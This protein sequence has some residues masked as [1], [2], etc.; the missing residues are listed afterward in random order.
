MSV[1]NLVIAAIVEEGAGGLRKVYQHGVSAEDF[2]SYEEEFRWIEDRAATKRPINIR[3][4]RRKFEDFEYTPTSERLQDM[5][6]D[7]KNERAYTEMSSLIDSLSAEL[8]VDNAVE[9]AGHA[10]DILAEVTRLH[11]PSSDFALVGGWREH[12]K[13]QRQIR[14][15]RN[16]GEPPGIP[17][18]F[19]H[20]DH[21][22]DGLVQGRMIVV[23]GRPGEGKS[24]L[25][26]A[27]AANASKQK[28]RTLLLSPEMNR[29][30]HLCRLHTLIS[31][32]KK[33]QK[34]CGLKGSFRNR[35]LMRGTGYNIK[36]YGRFMEFMEGEMG[37]IV[38]MTNTHRRTKMTPNF[39][40]A[41]IEEVNPDLVLIDPIYKLHSS[42]NRNSRIEELSDIA[43]AIQDMS[44]AYNIPVVVSNQAH[45]QASG[46]D[47]AP[48]KD[49]SFNSDV[50][51]QEADH[52]IGVKNLSQERRM[53]CRCSKSRFGHDFRFEMVFHPNTGVLQET[54]APTGDY[55]NGHE[56]EMEDEELRQIV[57]AATG[58]NT[59]DA[60]ND[61]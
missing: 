40:E 52:V 32:D 53:I 28:Y 37:E 14:T 16:A 1:E 30:E 60:S 44:E 42:K 36:S 17:T 50:P 12:L 24:Y 35:A 9:K 34:Q 23:L 6:P 19:E 4:F 59:A 10:R 3:V 29:R 21:H 47:D 58:R 18:G 55:L 15:L 54:S 57:A 61:D 33:V 5:L 38:L 48:H 41:K 31:A 43:D 49:S 46:K 8:E 25:M 7:L 26:A 45:R 27:F 39:I 2:V 51:V 56:E 22:W 11:A 20:I 13:E